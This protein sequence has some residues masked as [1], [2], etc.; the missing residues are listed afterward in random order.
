[1]IGR[2]TVAYLVRCA[3]GTI[4]GVLVSLN[5]LLPRVQEID[6]HDKMVHRYLLTEGIVGSARKFDGI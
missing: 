4:Q 6:V 1:M 5:E 2:P 3:A